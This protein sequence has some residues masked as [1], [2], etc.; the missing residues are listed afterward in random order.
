M[1]TVTPRQAPITVTLAAVVFLLAGLQAVLRMY[2]GLGGAGGVV[3][4]LIAAVIYLAIAF[5][6]WKGNKI[7]WI[8]AIIGGALALLSVFS[9]EWLSFVTGLVLL[10][11]LL[12]PQS[13]QW[14]NRS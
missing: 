9:G 7:A 2:D 8:L 1:T 13:R 3:V 11:L 12:L 6:L 14:F 10:V 5:G 4:A